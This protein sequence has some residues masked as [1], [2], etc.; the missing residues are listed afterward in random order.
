MKSCTWLFAATMSISGFALAQSPSNPGVT[1]TTD[2]A[3]IAEIEKHAQE[4]AARGQNSPAMGERGH[5]KKHGSHHQKNKAMHK[6]EK[7][8]KMP[9]DAPMATESKG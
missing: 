2:P 8:D 9:T 5:M 1:E 3:K 4:L 6:Q 7:K